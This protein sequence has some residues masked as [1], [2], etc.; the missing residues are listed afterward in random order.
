MLVLVLV[1]DLKRVPWSPTFMCRLFDIV[2]LSVPRAT[3]YQTFEHEHEDEHEK[4]LVIQLCN[5]PFR[6]DPMTF[7]LRK[8]TPRAA[9]E[10]D[11]F[12]GRMATLEDVLDVLVG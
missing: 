1:L 4:I 7:T 5:S 8:R 12:C 3:P 6:R 11:L 9:S 10:S 2:T